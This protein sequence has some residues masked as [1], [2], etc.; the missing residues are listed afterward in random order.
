MPRIPE[1]AAGL[2]HFWP[3][4]KQAVNG[5]LHVGTSR[6]LRKRAARGLSTDLE[7]A[8]RLSI[9]MRAGQSLTELEWTRTRARLLDL[10]TIL[11]A[12]EHQ[13]KTPEREVDNVV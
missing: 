7:S 3:L 2:F 9:E 8:A 12:W 6:Q 1:T 13:T 4:D 11:R 10:V 5:L